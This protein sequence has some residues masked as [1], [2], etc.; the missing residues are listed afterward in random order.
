[1]SDFDC[2]LCIG[3]EHLTIITVLANYNFN[4]NFICGNLSIFLYCIICYF[5][6]SKHLLCNCVRLSY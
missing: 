4:Y 6:Y 3:S 1:M 5:F 2:K